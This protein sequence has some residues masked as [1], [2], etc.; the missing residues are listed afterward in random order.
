MS[1]KTPVLSIDGLHVGIDGTPILHGIDLKIKPGEIHAI[2]GRNGSGKT[3][4]LY[5]SP[6]PRDG[7]LDRKPSSA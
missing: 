2:M 3:C 7:L 1:E 6:S 4:L 5:T